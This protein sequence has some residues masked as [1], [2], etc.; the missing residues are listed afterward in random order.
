MLLDEQRPVQTERS[1]WWQCGSLAVVAMVA[2]GF[3]MLTLAPPQPVQAA[4]SETAA[5]AAPPKGDGQAAAAKQKDAAPTGADESAPEKAWTFAC[6]MIDAVSKTP[7]EGVT[8]TVRRSVTSP[9][10]AFQSRPVL[11]ETTRRTGVDGGYTITIPPEQAAK[12]RLYIEIETRHP[13]YVDW[14]GGYSFSMA[15]V[16]QYPAS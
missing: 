15:I 5:D 3:S 16:S 2:V 11:Q 9:G 1:R 10:V 6:K 13:H 14:Y 4:P 8:V 7:I 12:R